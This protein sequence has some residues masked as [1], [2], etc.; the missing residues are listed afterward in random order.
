MRA[1]YLNVLHSKLVESQLHTRAG[2][3]NGRVIH[4]EGSW[5]TKPKPFVWTATLDE[6]IKKIE[7][8]RAKLEQIKPGCSLPEGK[9]IA[10]G[11]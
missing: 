7:R 10:T 8:A 11:T 5:N 2:G 9:K 6:I 4:S 3:V 1:A